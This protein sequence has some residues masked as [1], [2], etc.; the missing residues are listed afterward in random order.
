LNFLDRFSKKFSDIK[1]HEN[2]SNGSPVVP[3]RQTDRQ[4][5][6]G[7]TKLIVASIKAPKKRKNGPIMNN[8]FERVW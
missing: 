1:F 8:E 5:D 4:T 7:M 3:C 2:P 6:R